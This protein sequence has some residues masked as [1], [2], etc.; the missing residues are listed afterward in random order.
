MPSEPRI[1]FPAEVEGEFP[2]V[3]RSAAEVAANLVR[4]AIE[5]VSAIERWPRQTA[6]LLASAFHTLAILERAG[7]PLAAHVISEQLLVKVPA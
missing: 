2:D 4:T 6:S 1:R 3:S 7:G 5:L